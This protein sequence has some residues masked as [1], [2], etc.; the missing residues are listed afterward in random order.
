MAG[1][2]RGVRGE[3]LGGLGSEK[4]LRKTYRAPRDVTTAAP[5]LVTR[6]PHRSMEGIMPADAVA[7]IKFLI[8]LEPQNCRNR[9]QRN[10]SEQ[11]RSIDER[12]VG[13]GMKRQLT[14][15]RT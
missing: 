4:K 14:S 3:G 6:T 8:P 9:S 13:L 11:P 1:W 7:I 2:S 5:K 15:G 10:E 12:I